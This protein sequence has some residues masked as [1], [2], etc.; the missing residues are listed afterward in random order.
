MHVTPIAV[1][2]VDRGRGRFF[3]EDFWGFWCLGSLLGAAA[4]RNF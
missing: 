1:F 3:V 2:A 4:G